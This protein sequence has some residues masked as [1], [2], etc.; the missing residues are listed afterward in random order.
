MALPG[1]AMAAI[2]WMLIPEPPR[3]TQPEG[4]ASQQSLLQIATDLW[5]DPVFSFLN[6]GMALGTLSGYSF[7]MWAPTEFV[8]AY[9]MPQA[10]AAKAFGLAFG[11]AGLVGMLGF[12]FV[13]DHLL[14][15]NKKWPLRLGSIALAAATM[16]IAFVTYAPD[17]HVAILLAIPSGLLGGGWSIGV[18]ASLQNLLPNHI[19]ATGTALF[20]TVSTFIGM[21]FGPFIVGLL[22]DMFGGTTVFSLRFAM[23]A[24]ISTGI[25]GAIALWIAAI[26]FIT[27]PAAPIVPEHLPNKL[28]REGLNKTA[29]R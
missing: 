17:L 3:F 11:L 16:V 22:S 8:R 4:L 13:S 24:A 12:G 1:F 7:A 26:L 28:R 10:Q 29:M 27:N 21:V 9:H 25:P 6:L 5:K 2:A 18:M 20:L 14:K 19:R 15:Y 23:M